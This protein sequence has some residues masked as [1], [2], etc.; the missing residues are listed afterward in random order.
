MLSAQI[1]LM[2][3]LLFTLRCLKAFI[4]TVPSKSELVGG[5]EI[6]FLEKRITRHATSLQHKL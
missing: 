2:M 5:R 1:A 3:L 6:H 4:K